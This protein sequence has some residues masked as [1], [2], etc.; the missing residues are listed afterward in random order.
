MGLQ[1]PDVR[2]VAIR[3]FW[4]RQFIN[5]HRLGIDQARL[6]MT[7]VTWNS[8]VSSL[9]RKMR[10]RIMIEERRNPALG[11][12]AIR[13]GGLASLR[14]LACMRVFV[15]IFA[16]LR[17][18]LELHFLGARWHFVASATFN[19]AMCSEQRKLRF[20]VVITADVRP[21]P[22]VVASFAT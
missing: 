22:R 7:F 14:K 21:G 12:V 4:G 13:T 16:N 11:V 1:R 2:P 18:A 6:R 19:R 17:C 15:A 3:T 20:R 8:G 5:D 10:P 9:Q